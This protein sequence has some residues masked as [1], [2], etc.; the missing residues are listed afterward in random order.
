M[1]VLFPVAIRF[2]L[3]RVVVSLALLVLP[4]G[5]AHAAPF[6]YIP[7]YNSHDVSVIDTATNLVIATV[8]LNAS[9][10]AIDVAVNASGTRV[11]LLAGGGV[12]IID[13]A[14]NTVAGFIPVTGSLRGMAANHSGTRLYI[15]DTGSKSIVVVDTSINTVIGTVP[16]GASTSGSI[17]VDVNLAGTRVYVVNLESENVS[18]I[19]AV[20]NTVVATVVVGDE[21]VGV[22]VNSAGT[23]AYVANRR[24][25]SVSVIDAA[26]NTVVATVAVGGAAA[27][28]A[29]NPA[30]TRAYVTLQH[31][32]LVSVVDATT[33]TVVTS[34]AV[35]K[36]STGVDVNPAGTRVYV[37]NA[38]S[39]TVSVIDT[40]TNAVI[41]TVAV[42]TL[43]IALGH[44]IGPSSEYSR[45]YV[46]KAYVA[47]YGRPA[48]PGGQA[49]WAGRMDEEGQSLNAIIGA[50]GN[51][52]EFN[53]RYGGLTNT[54]LVTLIY[55]QALGRNPD[56]G[57]L[58]WYVA[59]LVAGRRTLQ[60]I[61]LDVLNGATTAPDSTIVANKL[62]V[63]AYF[64]AKVAV[65]C[66]YGTEQDG[67]DV[68]A[69]VTAL[70]ASVSGAKAAIDA[71]CGP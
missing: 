20:T 52:D 50:F 53:R 23:R 55:Q 8:Q 71:G 3:S 39:N 24:S 42:G 45:S 62:D 25:G 11:Y 63:A 66:A 22:A 32:G 46:Q 26:T 28:V 14:T 1:D 69:I 47:Y 41:T 18:V 67:V 5:L 61:T 56:Q 59:E 7:N 29:V 13:T 68:L 38:F 57:G 34:I 17:S 15:T 40:A 31:S 21:P 54:Q 2:A 4:T 16:L 12:S 64:T 60:T 44:F 58:D 65:G 30:G 10:G 43:P 36:G 33:N 70:D 9:S 27:G 48:D 35:G 51:S 37:A 19:D 49:Y 6:A